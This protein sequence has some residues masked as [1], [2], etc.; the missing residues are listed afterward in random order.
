MGSLTDGEFLRHLR[1]DLKLTQRELADICEISPDTLH[2]GERSGRLSKRT[3][4][5]LARGISSLG[6]P[7]TV[8]DLKKK[9]PQ[10][11]QQ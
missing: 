10:K 4:E 9:T 2:R 6:R 8:R 1:E 7:V 11:P 3:L 5:A